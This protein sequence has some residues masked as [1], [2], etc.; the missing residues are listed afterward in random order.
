[1]TH[2]SKGNIINEP[3][4]KWTLNYEVPDLEYFTFMKYSGQYVIF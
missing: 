4:Y 2:I 1:M 3:S